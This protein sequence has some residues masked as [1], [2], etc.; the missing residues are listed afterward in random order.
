MATWWARS[1]GRT[2]RTAGKQSETIAE[3]VRNASPVKINELRISSGPPTNATDSFIEAFFNAGDR[4]VDISNWYLTE[5]PTQQAIFST[6]RIPAGTELEAH[7]FYCGLANSGLA[8]AAR[9]GD[10]TIYV[11][12]TSGMKASDAVSIGTEA[13]AEARTILNLGTAARNH[14]TLWQPLPDGPVI[15]IPAGATNVPVMS[16]SGFVVGQEKDGS[17]LR[18]DISHGSRWRE[19]VRGGHGYRG[20]QARHASLHCSGCTCRSNE[21]QGDL[22]RRIPVR[23]RSGPTLTAW[24]M[25]RDCHGHQCRHAGDRHQ[26]L[27][28]C[29]RRSDQ[30]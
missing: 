26:S 6:L 29:K 15:N 8:A 3:K 13:N 16:T 2:R 30:E 19:A 18:R 24:A 14:T 27:G 21:H 17:R 20:G 4:P 23:D 10:T 28:Q 9:A 1:R 7:G 5:H 25:G 12:S 22:R 11:R